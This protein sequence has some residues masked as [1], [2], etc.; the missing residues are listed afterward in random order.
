MHLVNRLKDLGKRDRRIDGNLCV[1]TAN[2]FTRS[3][4]PRFLEI[5]SERQGPLLSPS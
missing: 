4:P 2:V 5:E 1:F 3:A